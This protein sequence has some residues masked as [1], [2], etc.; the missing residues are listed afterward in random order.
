MADLLSGGYT[1]SNSLYNVA[2]SLSQSQNN[3][4]G[5]KM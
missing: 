1:E 4:N 2:Y 5:I 3:K